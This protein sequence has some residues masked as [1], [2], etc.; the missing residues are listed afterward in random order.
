MCHTIAGLTL[1]QGAFIAWAGMG[2][3]KFVDDGGTVNKAMMSGKV[4]HGW[5]YGYV[6][7]GIFGEMLIPLVGLALVVVAFVSKAPGALKWAGILLGAIVAQIVL[8]M[9]GGAVPFLG[10][11]HGLFAFVLF[12]LCFVA[13]KRV[14]PGTRSVI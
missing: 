1:L 8:A 7:H 6:L 3:A 11:L 13:V 2:M 9:I 12:F 10:V 14:V 5:E 4:N